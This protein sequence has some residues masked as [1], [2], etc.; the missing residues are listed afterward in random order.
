PDLDRQAS[1]S[2]PPRRPGPWSRTAGLRSRS[3]GDNTVACGSPDAL[4]GSRV[5]V[6]LPGTVRPGLV[7]PRRSTRVNARK[8]SED[9]PALVEHVTYESAPLH[10]EGSDRLTSVGDCLDSL[11][12]PASEGIQAEDCAPKLC[13]SKPP[14]TDRADDSR[15]GFVGSRPVIGAHLS[16]EAS[17]VSPLVL[18][19]SPQRE[20]PGRR[21]DIIVNGTD[22][23]ALKVGTWPPNT[24]A[25]RR[26]RKEARKGPEDSITSAASCTPSVVQSREP[27]DRGRPPTSGTSPPLRF[28]GTG[29]RTSSHP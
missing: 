28:K 17:R 6:Q 12:R 3:P 11:D 15:T 18:C 4:R 5:P 25:G 7:A 23:V 22:D 2:G 27:P 21:P 24:L 29:T 26:A 9:R 19:R 20:T 14:V 1:E 16:E 8:G 10:R 13:Q